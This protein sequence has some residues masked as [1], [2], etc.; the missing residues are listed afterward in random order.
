MGAKA[1]RR[2]IEAYERR[3]EDEILHPTLGQRLSLR[4]CLLAQ[5]RQISDAVLNGRALYQPIGWR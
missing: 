5:A 2:L 3:L 4:R 1:K